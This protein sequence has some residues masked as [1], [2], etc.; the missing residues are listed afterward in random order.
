MPLLLTVGQMPD[1]KLALTNR[2]YVSEAI[3]RR[4][5]P[6]NTDLHPFVNIRVNGL[7]F[8]VRP[9]KA[10]ADN[11]IAMNVEQRK[12][13][14]VSVGDPVT[15]TPMGCSAKELE[16]IAYLTLTI[17]SLAVNVKKIRKV[18]YEDL[19]DVFIRTFLNQ[20]LTAGQC[21]LMD[22]DGKKF[23]A[24][25]SSMSVPFGYV[26][27]STKPTFEGAETIV[28]LDEAGQPVVQQ[29]ISEQPAQTTAVQPISVDCNGTN[30]EVVVGKTSKTI[31]ISGGGDSKVVVT[32]NY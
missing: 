19:Y 11:E 21:L 10:V 30:V 27:Y 4:I 25:I 24:K 18:E 7:M 9:D 16:P 5:A 20:P 17:D 31:T 22:V 6:E 3:F 28:I 26:S 14:G 15:L 23:S 12:Y 2:M 13:L 29:P 1:P 32:L 8:S